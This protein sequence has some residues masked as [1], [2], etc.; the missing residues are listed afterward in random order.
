MTTTRIPTIRPIKPADTYPLRHSVLW[1]DKPAAYVQL[2]EDAD[3]HHYGTFVGDE[4]VAVISLFINGTAARFRK[5]A[6]R[7]DKQGRG[8]GTALLNHTFAEARRLG[9]TTIG[10]DARLSAA[11]FYQRFAMQPAGDVFYK[12][13]IPYQRYET[14]LLTQF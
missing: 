7:P 4:L 14:A 5:F 11:P 12:G 6:T 9:A 10:C 13:T 1:P 2:P 8:I 3:G